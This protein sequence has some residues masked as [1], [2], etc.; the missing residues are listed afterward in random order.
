MGQGAEREQER[1]MISERTKAGLKAAKARGVQL[2]NA[3]MIAEQH[4]RSEAR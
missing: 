4:D 3:L 2:G 1:R